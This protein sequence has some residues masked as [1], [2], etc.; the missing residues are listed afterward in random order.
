MSYAIDLNARQSART[1]EQAIRQQ[2]QTV[3]EPRAWDDFEHL[4]CRLEMPGT[5]S[6]LEL[7]PTLTLT[8]L[9]RGEISI[10]PHGASQ[11]N[12]QPVCV[13]DLRTLAGTYV[14]AAILLGEQRYMFSSDVMRVLPGNGPEGGP[15][16]HVSRPNLLQV[17]QRRRFRRIK[18]SHSAQVDLS[19]QREGFGQM[20]GVAWLC[21]VSGDGMACRVEDRVADLLW[22]G[23][24]IDLAF[25]LAPGDAERY[26]LQAELVNKTPSGNAGKHILGFQFITDERNAASAE[27]A[28][29]LRKRLIERAPQLAD[30]QKG[31]DF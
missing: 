20:S 26:R 24:V 17:A 28:R 5:P 11:K 1:I 30:L 27:A 14:D 15:R 22:I 9:S 29:L 10:Q 4:L 21:N 23:D 31:V 13:D 6:E 16:L 2:A 25:T 19:W 18:L 7:V 3:L 12:P 8:V